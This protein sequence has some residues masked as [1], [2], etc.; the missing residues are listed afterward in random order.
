[1]TELFE[2]AVEISRKL[3]P[4]KQDA[5]ARIL[6]QWA[7]SDPSIVWLSADEEETM[8]ASSLETEGGE[9]AADN[10]TEATREEHWLLRH[11]RRAVAALDQVLPTIAS[12]VAR[13]RTLLGKA[14]VASRRAF[15]P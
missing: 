10:W 8:R 5:L 2:Q 7:E 3:P 13:R 11:T 9:F 15:R 1:M 12:L 14:L 6:L 4:E